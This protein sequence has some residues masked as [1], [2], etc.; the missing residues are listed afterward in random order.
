MSGASFT[1]STLSVLS[2]FGVRSSV[3]E[4]EPEPE[5]DPEP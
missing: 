5:P 3:V 4:P 1:V 2:V